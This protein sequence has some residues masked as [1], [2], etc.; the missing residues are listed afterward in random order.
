MK[1]LIIG[2]GACGASAAARLR[3]L[4][5]S[6]EII[7]LEKPLKFQLQIAVCLIIV[8]DILQMRMLCMFLLQRSLRNF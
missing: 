7:I 1:V 4:D 3:R 6:A 8:P 5:D 2:G